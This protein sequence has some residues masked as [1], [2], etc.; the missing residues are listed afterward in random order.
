MKVFSSLLKESDDSVGFKSDIELFHH[1]CNIWKFFV[2]FFPPR[3]RNLKKHRFENWKMITIKVSS[4]TFEFHGI[5]QL[6]KAL[7]ISN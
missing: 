3:T 1:F 4:K 7:E 6:G 2:F 5:R